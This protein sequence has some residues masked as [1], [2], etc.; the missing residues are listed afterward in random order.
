MKATARVNPETLGQTK[1]K[2]GSAVPDPNASVEEWALFAFKEPAAADQ[3]LDLPNPALGN[4]VP[5]LIAQT[6]EGAR[7]VVAVLSRFVYGDYA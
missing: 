1:S 6:E 4:R 5:R 2:R 3:F 7:E